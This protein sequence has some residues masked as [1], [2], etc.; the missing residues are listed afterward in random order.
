MAA[1]CYHVTLCGE[2]RGHLRILIGRMQVGP[3][4][5]RMVQNEHVLASSQ[6][7]GADPLVRVPL[8]SHDAPDH[9]R[10]AHILK[11]RRVPFLISKKLVVKMCQTP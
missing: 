5:P 2:S 1:T 7:G 4:P 8:L 11:A 3:F 9:K 10:G 6:R